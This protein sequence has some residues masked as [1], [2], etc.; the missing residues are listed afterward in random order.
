MKINVFKFIVPFGVLGVIALSSFKS[1]KTIIAPDMNI[2][3]ENFTNYKMK[4][5]I[6][7]KAFSIMPAPQT[8]RIVNAEDDTRNEITYIENIKTIITTLSKY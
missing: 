8:V 5:G 4:E 3:V 6:S 7:G 2:Q 1:A